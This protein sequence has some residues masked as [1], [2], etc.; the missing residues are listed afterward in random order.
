[1]NRDILVSEDSYRSPQF[2][3]NRYFSCVSWCVLVL[4]A[5]NLE[6]WNYTSRGCVARSREDALR[7]ARL[8]LQSGEY[9]PRSSW[10]ASPCVSVRSSLNLADFHSNIKDDDESGRLTN[11]RGSWTTRLVVRGEASQLLSLYFCRSSKVSRCNEPCLRL[12][13]ESI[14]KE[15]IA[16]YFCTQCSLSAFQQLCAGFPKSMLVF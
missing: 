1:M 4:S 14:T 10:H 5:V 13:P 3:R 6:M 15:S 8:E 2:V 11:R 16:N 12:A 7:D 9:E